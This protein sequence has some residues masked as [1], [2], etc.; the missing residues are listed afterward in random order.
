M[1][2][3]AKHVQ[4]VFRYWGLQMIA[5]QS[6]R[7]DFAAE[8][9]DQHEDHAAR[10]NQLLGW[11]GKIAR[12]AQQGHGIDALQ[13][14][15]SELEREF[16]ADES[17][18]SSAIDD[19]QQRADRHLSDKHTPETINAIFVAAFPNLYLNLDH[20]TIRLD[21]ETEIRR[22]AD[23][24]A[25]CDDIRRQRRTPQT[26]IEA[27]MYAVRTRGVAALK[28]PTNIERLSRCDHAAK[29]E[30]NQ[31]IARLIAAKKITP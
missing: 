23:I 4:A 2:A 1:S 31:R 19:L 6:K 11:Q 5:S 29:D 18:L 28:E 15:L 25:D 26:S 12:E 30:I 21:A 27:I 22:P 14:I 8:S 16:G 20:V 7:L 3:W 9:D 13:R 24:N 10:E 17:F